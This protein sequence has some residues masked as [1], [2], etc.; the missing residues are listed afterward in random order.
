VPGNKVG[1]V[2]NFD[3]NH[4][5]NIIGVTMDCILTFSRLKVTVH[6]ILKTD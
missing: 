2:L 4:E 1:P 3:L 5:L 6:G